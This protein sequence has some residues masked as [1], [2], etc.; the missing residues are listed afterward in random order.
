M[1]DSS[2]K[3]FPNNSCSSLEGS[4][5]LPDC[6][7]VGLDH[8]QQNQGRHLCPLSPSL[9]K[10][11]HDS[12]FVFYN[13]S[14]VTSTISITILMWRHLAWVFFLFVWPSDERLL[15]WE[16]E[17]VHR[18]RRGELVECRMLLAQRGWSIH[19][20]STCMLQ[21]KLINHTTELQCIQ[22]WRWMI[23]AARWYRCLSFALPEC[24][25]LSAWVSGIRQLGAGGGKLTVTVPRL[26]P[27][28]PS[29]SHP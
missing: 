20:P 13:C 7:G 25:V 15:F 29:P 2:Y 27:M 14:H 5:E 3:S 4:V 8:G 1:P 12:K 19:V 6:L 22:C 17:T 26:S 28:S 23:N 10:N 16:M 24:L 21:V 18:P 9:W 11:E